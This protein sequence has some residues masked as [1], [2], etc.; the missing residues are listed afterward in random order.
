M[1]IKIAIITLWASL[2]V[3]CYEDKGNY[4]LV[5]Y[6]K[7][8]ITTNNAETKTTV[9]LGETVKITPKITW[10]Y[11]DRDTTTNAFEFAWVH[12]WGGDTLAKTKVLEYIPEEC[13]QFS[14]YLY[15]TEKATGVVTRWQASVTV[16]TPY[17]NGWIILSENNGKAIL[18]YIRRDSWKDDEN[19]THYFWTNFIDLYTQ[20]HPDDPLASEV[21]LRVDSYIVSNKDDE[22]VVIFEGGRASVL[23]GLDFGKVLEIKDEF[24]GGA[25]PADFKAKQFIR[26]G[27]CD[28]VLGTNGSLY[29]RRNSATTEM[30]HEQ[31]FMNVAVYFPG[32]GAEISEFFDINVYKADF[33]LGYDQLHKRFVACYTSFSSGNSYLGG[34]IDIINTV[35]PT[36]FADILNL[37][38]YKLLYCGDF[39]D[40]KNYVNILKNEST[41]KYLIQT[42][43]LSGGTTSLTVQE[44][45]QEEFVGGDKVSDNTV[46]RRLRLASYLYFGEGNKLYFY[47]VNTKQV[48]LYTA[49]PDG[50]RITHMMEDAEGKILGVATD[51]GYFY[52]IDAVSAEILGAPD[53]GTVGIIH[54]V[55]GLGKIKSLT[56]KWGGSFNWIFGGYNY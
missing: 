18:N 10:K 45:S 54:Q 12:T 15:V 2:L 9:N 6:N 35:D 4:D 27:Y 40:G 25:Y 20:L 37:E 41:G 38:G 1:K 8:T 11:P 3:A 17:K 53:P 33:I 7:I 5:D 23:N 14:C 50:G 28:F 49:F 39:T 31:M 22:V 43:K 46:F 52:L 13:G 26:G 47:D 16:N 21:P 32:G 51:N 42:Y 30:K 34:K 19:K 29:W 24:P 36:T 44:A 48:K 55:S 56:W